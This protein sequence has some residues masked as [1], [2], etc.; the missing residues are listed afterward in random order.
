MMSRTFPAWIRRLMARLL[1]NHKIF[2]DVGHDEYWTDSQVANVQAAANAG[3]NLA[4]MSGN[5]IFW[6]TRFEPSIAGGITANRTLVSY[7]DSH[8]QTVVDPNGTGTGTFE[9]PANMGGAAMP[10]NA[11]TGTNFQVDQVLQSWAITIPYGESQLRIWR[12]TSVANT[13]PGQTATLASGLL[14]YEWDSSPDNGFQPVGLVDLSST[15]VAETTAYNTEFGSVDTSGTATHNLVE[16]RDPTSGALVF[17]AGTVFWSWGLSDQSY[18]TAI[19]CL[20]AGPKCPA[21]DGEP[22]R[23]YGRSTFNASGDSLIASADNRSHAAKVHDLQRLDHHSGRGTVGYGYRDR[24]G[25]RWRR[26]AG[27]DVSTDGGK[28]WHPANSPVGTASENWSYTFPAPAPGTYTIEFL[29][30]DD[31]LDLET[32]GPGTPYA[33][34]PS[35][36]LSLFSPSDTPATA[37]VNDPN[38]V[39]VGL[40]FT[41][42][43]SGE[44]TGIAST[45]DR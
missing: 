40:K 28:T 35:S 37:D 31:S 4:F 29:A 16:Y 13:A 44:I 7:K 38:A 34:S 14:G 5:E 20:A 42:T 36:A 30:V 26:D 24:Y 23:R 1:L 12:N 45:R 21:G 33:V 6:Q 9:A 25:R 41:S 10:T 11:L 43:T 2:M 8:F 3:V 15:T 19:C 18:G 17:G 32:P 39:E 22:V 27:V